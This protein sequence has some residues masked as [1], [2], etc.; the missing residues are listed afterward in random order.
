MAPLDG[1]QEVPPVVTNASGLTTLTLNTEQTALDFV[2]DY[3]DSL[4][5]TQA[6]IHEAPVGDNG[7]V[8]LFTVYESR[9]WTERYADM[10]WVH[11]PKGNGAVWSGVPNTCSLLNTS[12][13]LFRKSP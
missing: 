10:S 13:P 7:P 9:D 8:C 12:A 3:T 5:I 11:R 2:Q 4:D 6:H 1:D